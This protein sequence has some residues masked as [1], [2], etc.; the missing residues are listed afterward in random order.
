MSG[1]WISIRYFTRDFLDQF[2][3]VLLQAGK[4]RALLQPL[5]HVQVLVVLD[6]QAV[7]PGLRARVRAH[8]LDALVRIVHLHAVAHSSK[9]LKNKLSKTKIAGGAVAVAE[10]EI[11]A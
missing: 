10:D 2:G 3:E 5:A 9:N 8:Q 11:G 4:A 7:A 6:L 1:G